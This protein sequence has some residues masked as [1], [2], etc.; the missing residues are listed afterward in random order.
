MMRVNDPGECLEDVN[1]Q[2][3]SQGFNG[4]F[5]TMS[6]LV[7]DTRQ[8]TI[9]LAT[10]GHPA[11]LFADA[12]G[13]RRLE[14]EPELVLGVDP[15]AAYPTKRLLLPSDAR[16]LLYTD[17]VI[18]AATTAGTRFSMTGLLAALA[19]PSTDAQE[20]VDAVTRAVDRFRH[21]HDLS[22]D[23]TLVAIQ[24]QHPATNAAETAQTHAGIGM[25]PAL[26]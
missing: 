12:E 26:V 21:G 4:Q 5:V 1:R 19:Q 13:F 16:I 20:M 23:L 24:L 3:C 8:H 6:L 17:G 2:L 11:P 15:D 7:L 18:D 25:E 22:D 14:I 10:A 9:Q